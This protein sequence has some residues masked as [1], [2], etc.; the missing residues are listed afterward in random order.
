MVVDTREW[1]CT[2]FWIL[3]RNLHF[4]H[5]CVEESVMVFITSVLLFLII[6][7]ESCQHFFHIKIFL[8]NSADGYFCK[9]FAHFLQ[10]KNC[11][12]LPFMHFYK[13]VSAHSFNFSDYYIFITY[14]ICICFHI[15]LP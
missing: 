6:S 14:N 13:S 5:K 8:Q 2:G 12:S 4:L 3:M 10:F 7:A 15:C 9:F 1:I 11:F